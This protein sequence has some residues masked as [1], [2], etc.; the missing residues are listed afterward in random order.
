[1]ELFDRNGAEF[2]FG[3]DGKAIEA[4]GGEVEDD[5]TEPPAGDDP[6]DDPTDPTDP[7]GGDE[8]ETL[9]TDPDGV[10]IPEANAEKLFGTDFEKPLAEIGGLTA[11]G[12]G[13]AYQTVDGGNAVQLT[14]NGIPT[15]NKYL[16]VIQT[17][18]ASLRSF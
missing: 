12:S 6:T 3:L 16:S 13:F 7:E 15:E 11:V 1:M 10:N 18:L 2:I 17:P 8:S 9:P 4:V 5:P 14:V